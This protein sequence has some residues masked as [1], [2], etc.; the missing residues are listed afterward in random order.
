M[1]KRPYR[2]ESIK[3]INIETIAKATEGRRLVVA[4]DV[5]KRKMRA[6]LVTEGREVLASVRWEHSEETG[7][8]LGLL[9][10]LSAAS[11]EV[12]MEPSGTYGHALMHLCHSQWRVFLVS[13]KKTHD[14]AELF[15]G[16]PSTHD[17]K[18][19]QIIARL[20]LDGASRP[21]APEPD[22]RR[23][24]KAATATMDRYNARY[25]VGMNQLEAE[26]ARA[27]PELPGLLELNNATILD[28]LAVFPGPADARTRLAELEE[29]MRQSS[30]GML[31]DEKIQAV[32]TAASSS[33]GVNLSPGERAALRELAEDTRTARN[34]MQTAKERLRVLAKQ[35]ET[36]RNLTPMTGAVTAAVLAAIVGEVHDY[37]HVGA[38][39]KAIGINLRESSSGEHA[40]RL[41]ITKRGSGRA[42]KY[43]YLLALRMVLKNQIVKAWFERKVQRDGGK[44]MKAVIAVMRKV[45]K[46]LWHVGRGATFNAEKLF[47]MRLL[48]MPQAEVPNG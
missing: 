36:A 21:W 47:D 4:V 15:D 25:L 16:V 23:D 29:L 11:I 35:S 22:T 32:L 28:L 6:A 44:K 48:N 40:G 45:A 5:A 46:A 17:G 27:W 3:Q 13:G 14:A 12:V 26:L 19:A 9:K 20:H 31:S 33:M 30:K 37:P 34:Q 10:Q 38:Y 7:E 1:K 18:C 39:L 24:L 42:R 41:A 2:T 8:F 43:L